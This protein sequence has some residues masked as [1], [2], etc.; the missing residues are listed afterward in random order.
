LDQA[1]I[2]LYCPTSLKPISFA[3]MS[4]VIYGMPISGN[5]I[6][7]MLLA[8]DKKCGKLEMMNIMEGA[9]KTPEA[10]AINPFHQMPSMKDGE[11]CLAES[12]AILRY[13]A[14]KYGPEAYG[15]KDIKKQAEI[16]WALDWASTNFSANYKTIWYPVA[17]F[18]GP[19][20]DQ[21]KANEDCVTNLGVFA[22]KFLSK[23]KFITGDTLSIGDY[24]CGALFWYIGLPVIK[25]K[26]GFELP[27]R[28]V[29]YV[30]DFEEALGAEAKEFLEGPKGFIAS[31]A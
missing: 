28:I 25:D 20:E 27:E 21:K 14:K 6:P 12:N 19:P 26:T 18:G 9:H 4:C 1:P 3:T 7:A 29:K 16:D 11:F 30:A 24:K 23:G 13:M 17:G 8:L 2:T 31:K 22:E 10:L 5:V 15:D